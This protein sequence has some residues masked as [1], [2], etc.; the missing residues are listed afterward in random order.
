MKFLFSLIFLVG[1]TYLSAQQHLFIEAN[2]TINGNNRDLIIASNVNAG[3]A[4][5]ARIVV[6]SGDTSASQMQTETALSSLAPSY[7][8]SPGYAGYG[9]LSNNTSGLIMRSASAAGDMKFLVGGGSISN[10][11]MMTI[12]NNGNI[13]IGTQTP[14]S[15]IEI[16]NGDVYINNLNSGVIMKS[17]NGTCWRFQPTNSGMAN[18]TQLS[19]CP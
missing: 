12:L 13:G 19:S 15:R 3:S 14:S 16:N 5:L 18:F 8:A 10:N 7:I 11:T 6:L 1:T 9:V 4:S 2:G 17:P